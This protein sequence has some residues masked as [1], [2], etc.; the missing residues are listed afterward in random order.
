MAIRFGKYV[1]ITSGVA[2]QAAVFARELIGRIFTTNN[3]LPPQSFAEFDTADEVG[4]YF[5]T[6]SEEYLRAVFYFG[7]VSKSITRAKKISYARWV[8]AAVAPMIFGVSAN[9]LLAAFTAITA[10]SFTLSLGGTANVIGPLNFST[11]GSLAAVATRIQT[12][13]RTNTGAQWTSATV[14][15]DA[16]N[17][18]F[19][20][21]GGVTGTAAI[22]IT[23]GAQAL[24][25]TLGWL[26]GAI[27]ANGSAIE[28]ITTT[29]QQSADTSDNF[30][31][32]LFE[33]T[34]S[35]SQVTEAATWNDAQNVKF[36]Y[37]Q[38]VASVD[39]AAWSAAL[40]GIAGI[41]L[42]VAGNVTGEYQ[43]MQPM[44][45]LA[46]TDYARRDAT[47]N[48]MFQQFAITPTVT[49]T[50]TSDTYDAARINYYGQTQSAGQFISFYQ[51]GVLMGLSTD[52]VDMNTYANEMWLKS[53]AGTGVMSLFLAKA[54]VSANV[55]GRSEILSTIQVSAVQPGLFNGTISVGKTLTPIQISYIND[56][57]G[58]SNAWRQV[59]NSGYWLDVV[60]APFSTTD[61]RTEY[62][63]TYT[64]V[65]SKD[66]VVRKV[67]GTHSLI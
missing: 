6:G 13:I 47:Q 4:S 38:H 51:R 67:E 42:T 22:A 50:A 25:A 53:A 35:L 66:D 31:S 61:G 15:Y 44:M 17:K 23:E 11:D 34:L 8:N 59:Q 36:M 41:G 30:G 43:S 45:I 1:S 65:Y 58:D 64:L 9:Y 63:A 28:T 37:T 54:K 10:G 27:L 40:I 60:I 2:G 12:A 21:V 19:N 7:W 3:Q 29:L 56:A 16:T 5:G 39:Y 57:T 20:F 55:Q 14:S 24:A 52:P 62:K 49:D 48:Y 46:A 32:F 33:P 26:T 18:R